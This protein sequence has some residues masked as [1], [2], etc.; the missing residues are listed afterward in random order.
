VVLH[1]VPRSPG[2]I[3]VAAASFY[4]HLFC[5]GD[6][7]MINIEPVPKRLING[8]RKT[9]VDK[10][11]D[12]LLA[13]IVVNPENIRLCECTLEVLVKRFGALLILPKRLLDDQ[14]PDRPAAARFFAATPKKL[15]AVAR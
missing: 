7:N 5:D 3:V 9:E 2:D 13:E 15:G 10:V 6:L 11:L 1:H 14:T 12:G 4:T 8:V